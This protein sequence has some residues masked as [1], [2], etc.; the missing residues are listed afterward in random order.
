MEAERGRDENV[1]RKIRAQHKIK[2]NVRHNTA[3]W[4]ERANKWCQG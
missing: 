3:K 2:Q 1:W 4:G